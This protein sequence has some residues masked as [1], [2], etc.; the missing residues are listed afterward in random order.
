[1]GSKWASD[2]ITKAKI[3]QNQISI[4]VIIEYFTT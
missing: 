1:M 2:V 4:F 3:K